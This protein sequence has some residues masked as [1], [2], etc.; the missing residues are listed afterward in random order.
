MFKN[1]I[2]KIFTLSLSASLLSGLFSLAQAGVIIREKISYYPVV[3]SNGREIIKSFKANK[4]KVNHKHLFGGKY[5]IAAAD[6]RIEVENVKKINRNNY[7]RIIDAD[8]IVNVSYTYP[9]WKNVN[10]ASKMMRAEWAKFLEYAV[11]HEKQHVKLAE[12]FAKDYLQL[13][14]VTK[15]PILANCT[16]LPEKVNK[17]RMRLYKKHLKQQKLFDLKEARSVGL[18]KK[19]L[20]SLMRAK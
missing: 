18:G 8:I 12:N 9:K 15:F 17:K 10:S 3:G 13:L 19:R 1:S 6:F 5:T 11:W 2:A 16:G 7:C 4:H 14:R 20:A